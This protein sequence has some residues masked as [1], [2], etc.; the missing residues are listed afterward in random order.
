MLDEVRQGLASL[1]FTVL[2]AI[3]GK[4]P[5]PM[6]RRAISTLVTIVLIF[7]IILGGVAIIVVLIFFPGAPSTTT[8]Y[9]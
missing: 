6:A 3:R 5:A 2:F 9:P 8:V 4:F 1:F 7:V